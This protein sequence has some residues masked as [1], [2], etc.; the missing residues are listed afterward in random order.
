M[1]S[2]HGLLHTAMFTKQKPFPP[3]TCESLIIRF[4][5]G[6]LCLDFGQF[7]AMMVFL[8]QTKTIFYQ[9]DKNSDGALSCD[10]LSDAFARSGLPL[11]KELV[12]QIGRGFDLDQSG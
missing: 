2:L 10:E 5:E 4:G 8:K 11:P 3:Q 9:L 12:V 7:C 6:N 1:L